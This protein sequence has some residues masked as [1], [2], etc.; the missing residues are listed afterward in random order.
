MGR[1]KL[2]KVLGIPLIALFVY[3]SI[4]LGLHE[5]VHQWAPLFVGFVGFVIYAIIVVGHIEKKRKEL[6]NEYLE[7]GNEEALEKAFPTKKS[8]WKW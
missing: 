5:S 3:L 1:L 6:M 7:T 8:W 4:L 2:V